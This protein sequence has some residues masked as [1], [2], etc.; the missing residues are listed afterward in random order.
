V[1]LDS[2]T[3]SVVVAGFLQGTAATT[4]SALADALA[5]YQRDFLEGLAIPEPPFEGWLLGERERLR[6]QALEG[7]GRL[8]A[9][10]RAAG[11][12]EAAVQTRAAAAGA[13]PAAGVRSPG[14]DATLCRDGAAWGGAPP[15]STL[16]GSVPAGA[17]GGA[18]ARDEGPLPGHP[19]PPRPQSPSPGRPAS[20]RR[21]ARRPQF[22]PGMSLRSP[23]A[24]RS[25]R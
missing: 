25:L 11:A 18:R 15:V 7:L 6:E 19:A 9:Y 22:S 8:L 4:A 16:R 12:T 13:G 5:L 10:Q 20:R 1:A 3:V 17:P 21:L 2:H 14:A 24:S 23:P